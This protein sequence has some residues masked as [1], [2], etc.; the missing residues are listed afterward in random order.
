MSTIEDHCQ[1][2]NSVSFLRWLHRLLVAKSKHARRL[3]GIVKTDEIYFLD[4]RKGKQNYNSLSRKRGGKATK[5]G[6]SYQII[7]AL[8]V[9]DRI[10]KM[11]VV[12]LPSANAEALH[13][14]IQPTVEKA[15][16]LMRDNHRAYSTC[17]AAIG[18]R[19]Q[20]LNLSKKEH[21]PEPFH[22]QNV[23]IRN[24]QFNLF[25]HHF[26]YVTTKLLDKFLLWFNHY[27][28]KITLPRT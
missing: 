23:K 27:E 21:V 3:K 26:R 4:N 28:L 5:S 25:M 1:M 22:I 13:I 15:T 18:V 10:G 12:K 7:L 24:I 11:V 9:A 17:A 6:L 14:V 8:F 2:A 19:H 16:I 20:I